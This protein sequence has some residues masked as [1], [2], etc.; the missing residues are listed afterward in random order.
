MV[1]WLI[2]LSVIQSNSFMCELIG[3]ATYRTHSLTTFINILGSPTF[4][5][6]CMSDSK[7]KL[8]R[9]STV[10]WHVMVQYNQKAFGKYS[11]Q[12]L[13]KYSSFIVSP[14]LKILFR[15]STCPLAC[16]WARDELRCLILRSSQ[17]FLKHVLSN[18]F[19]LSVIRV[20]RMSN[21]QMIFLHTKLVT[22]ELD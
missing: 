12:R 4:I 1:N 13:L 7:V 6:N 15:I 16:W 20:G 11:A 5:V 3:H 17:N 9:V 8:K 14:C 21:R 18:C 22:D 19:S 2:L 10:G